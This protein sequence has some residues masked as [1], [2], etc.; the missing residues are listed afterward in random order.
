MGK[1]QSGFFIPAHSF[2]LSTINWLQPNRNMVP[3]ISLMMVRDGPFSGTSSAKHSDSRILAAWFSVI[4]RA[5][6]TGTSMP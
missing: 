1:T 5:E 6:L 2:L 3:S 4:T